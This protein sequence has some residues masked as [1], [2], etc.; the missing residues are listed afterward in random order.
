MKPVHLSEAVGEHLHNVRG[1]EGIL[2]NEE[3]KTALIEFSQGGRLMGDDGGASGRLINEGHFADDGSARGL[4]DHFVAD[5]DGKRAIKED[6]HTV[7]R[8]AGS[9]KSFAFGQPHRVIFVGK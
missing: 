2:L 3:L 9:K 4:L 8:I 1:K 7:G 6:E 5:H